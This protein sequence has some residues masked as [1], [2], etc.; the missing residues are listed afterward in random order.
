MIKKIENRDIIR[1]G[2]QKLKGKFYDEE[3]VATFAR[4]ISGEDG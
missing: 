1:G 3:T 2:I 4:G